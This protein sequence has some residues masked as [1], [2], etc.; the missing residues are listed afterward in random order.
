[1]RV[2]ATLDSNRQMPRAKLR[3]E[4]HVGADHSGKGTILVQLRILCRFPPTEYRGR[5]DIRRHVAVCQSM[6][7]PRGPRPHL[8]QHRDLPGHGGYGAIPPPS[9]RE[10]QGRCIAVIARCLAPL[11]Y[12]CSEGETVIVSEDFMSNSKNAVLLEVGL[13]GRI[14]RF[15][16]SGSAFIRFDGLKKSHWVWKKNFD[17]LRAGDI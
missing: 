7:R 16:D 4:D 6:A 8:G 17:K 5:P 1:M 14:K 3:N 2:A 11:A 13:K 10:A 15:G 9:W 12:V